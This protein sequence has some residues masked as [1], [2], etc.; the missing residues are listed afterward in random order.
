MHLRVVQLLLEDNH[1]YG[2]A[3]R[4]ECK[5]KSL[6]GTNLIETKYSHPKLQSEH[7]SKVK[8]VACGSETPCASSYCGAWAWTGQL[9]PLGLVP[10]VAQG[11]LT[12]SLLQR[13][14]QQGARQRG[15]NSDP[16]A[17]AP[18]VCQLGA[19]ARAGGLLA[20][21]PRSPLLSRQRVR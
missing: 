1:V 3:C 13:G 19:C 11:R 21:T 7:W 4:K 8:Q 2:E 6:H 16:S 9:V 12:F 18:R 10:Q 5:S 14:R 20:W 15:W 17:H